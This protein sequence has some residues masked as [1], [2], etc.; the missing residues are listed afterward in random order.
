MN[1]LFS[2]SATGQHCATSGCAQ[3]WKRWCRRSWAEAGIDCWVLIG[4]E[5]NEDPVLRTMLPATWEGARRR[6]ILVFTDF[7][8]T[9][10]AVSRYS[11]GSFFPAGMGSERRAGP[12]AMSGRLSRETPR[13][14][15][16]PSTDPDTFPLA[17]GMTATE[18]E[19]FTDSLPVSLR[20]LVVSERP[21]SCRRLA[22]DEDQPGDGGVPRRLCTCSPSVCGGRC[23]PKLSK[24]E[25]R[26]PGMWSGGFVR[27]PGVPGTRRGS[28]LRS[29]R[30]GVARA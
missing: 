30:N 3:G 26:R 2:L 28:I 27:S 12:M 19:R 25:R 13:R 5:Y 18:T 15:E 16:L 22:G 6:T 24:P 4:R 17:D 10:M 7:G 8:H 11:V 9:R 29:R 14:N 20:A 1:R 21:V 23:H